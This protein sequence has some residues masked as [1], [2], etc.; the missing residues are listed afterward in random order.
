MESAKGFLAD[1]INKQLALYKVPVQKGTSA[2]SFDVFAKERY[3]SVLLC[4]TKNSR[5]ELKNILK[6]SP[7]YLKE[8]QATEEYLKCVSMVADEFSKEFAKSIVALARIAHWKDDNCPGKFPEQ[9]I[10][11]LDA[12]IKEIFPDADSWGNI[13]WGA[14]AKNAENFLMINFHDIMALSVY[15]R[16]VNILVSY[17]NKITK[18][19]FESFRTDL[20]KVII[21]DVIKPIAYSLGSEKP[22]DNFDRQMLLDKLYLLQTC[23]L[24]V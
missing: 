21:E 4:L 14:I 20:I 13:A 12:T 9:L 22:L 10:P 11:E 3:K 23:L 16:A 2:E 1:F 6:L 5:Q 8:R 17:D 18:Q 7:P 24:T 15:R 19:F